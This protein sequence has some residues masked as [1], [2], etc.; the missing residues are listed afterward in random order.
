MAIN[1]INPMFTRLFYWRIAIINAFVVSLV[2]PISSLLR[3]GYHNEIFAREFALGFLFTLFVWW[4]NLNAY[5]TIEKKLLKTKNQ[6]LSQTIRVI[7]TITASYLLIY[8][9]ERLGIFQINLDLKDYIYPEY[10]NEFRAVITAVIVLMIVFFLD[11]SD[12]FYKARI[13]NE[14]L[15]LENSIAQFETLKQQINPHFLFNSLNILKTMIKSNDAKA[16]EY[17]L[18][19]SELYRSLLIS[20]QKQTV[21]ITEELGVLENY[22]YMLKAR[23]QEKIL[24]TINI[25]DDYKSIFI[26]PFTL[27]MLVEN[28]IKHNIVS[29]KKPLNI[30]IKIENDELVVRNNLQLKRT[31]EHSNYIGLNNIN[32]RFFN[33]IGKNINIIK[34]EFFFTVHLPLITH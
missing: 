19:L 2:F 31:V 3:I 27:Q 26:P 20:N 12:R 34:D 8:V 25:P 33:N 5:P 23:F 15:K 21:P 22:I 10:G 28:C 6:F 14:Q 13:E 9:D 7:S 29:E 17:V 16:E 24:L 11:V 32:S 1:R 30:E 4:F 18:R